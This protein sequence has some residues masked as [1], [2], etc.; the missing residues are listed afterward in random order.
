MVCVNITNDMDI[1]SNKLKN[2]L[3]LSSLEVGGS[4]VN[5]IVILHIN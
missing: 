1:I 3:Q 5:F 2:L 4:R